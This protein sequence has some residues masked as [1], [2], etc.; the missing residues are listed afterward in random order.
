MW[1]N[2]N[3]QVLY[4]FTWLNLLLPA[5]R[6]YVAFVVFHALLGGAGTF[7][8]A[9][10]IGLG[11][12]GALVASTVWTASGP[13]LSLVS[14]WNHLAAAAWLPWILAAA[15]RAL[16]APSMRA[17]VL[18]GAALAVPVLVGSPDLFVFAVLLAPCSW[19]AGSRCA[20]SAARPRAR[21]PAPSLCPS[22][23]LRPPPHTAALADLLG[24]S[25][26]RDWSA[27]DRDFWS[28]HPRLLGQLVLPAF[29][30]TLPLAAPLRDELFESRE[31]Y[32]HSH[33]LGLV[34]LGLVA[35]ALA[36]PRRPLRG[37]LVVASVAAALFAL[38]RHTPFYE[39]SLALAPPLGLLR[40]PSKA[41]I[42]VTLAWA[43]L[44]GMGYE[45]W[46]E[47]LPRRRGLA[48]VGC[49]ALAVA[50]GATIVFVFLMGPRADALAASVLGRSPGTAADVA[51]APVRD[52]RRHRHRSRRHRARARGLVGS[53][54]RG[55]TERAAGGASPRSPWPISR[56]PTA[57]L[58]P[59]APVG[60]TP[61]IRLVGPRPPTRGW[62][63]LRVR[64]RDVS[65]ED[66]ASTC[67]QTRPHAVRAAGDLAALTPWP[68]PC[69]TTAS[70]R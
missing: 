60:S 11:R 21:G 55:E 17:V 43:L 56:S 29:I 63:R 50:A 40:F 59:T 34:A 67:V 14:L 16:G 25:S 18:W 32:L 44:A 30:D 68:S 4:P 35:A 52:R 69:A 1:A 3:N 51:F 70:R 12:A 5:P 54:R 47:G 64:L 58:N 15:E 9:R 36:G 27:Y 49:L 61:A 22:A 48:V 53:G 41:L 62:P 37:T 42:V 23:G 10:R 8:L 2:M 7:V 39:V 24:H 46:R 57:P 66:A 6:Y 33:Y 26:R 65:P 38:G 13:A 31:P 28:I 19:L 45:A 20:P